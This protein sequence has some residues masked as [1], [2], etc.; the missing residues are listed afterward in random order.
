[1]FQKKK[2]EASS[3]GQALQFSKFKKKIIHM[4]N[5]YVFKSFSLAL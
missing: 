2:K 1:M 4:A 5:S 3:K